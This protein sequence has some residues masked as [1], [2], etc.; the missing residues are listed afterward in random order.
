VLRVAIIMEIQRL[1]GTELRPGRIAA[2]LGANPWHLPFL[3]TALGRH[4]KAGQSGTPRTEL[5]LCV[6]H[7]GKEFRI[8]YTAKPEEKLKAMPA[9]L[10]INPAVIWRTIQPRLEK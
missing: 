7:N 9:V 4:I 2:T 5:F 1:F 10:V 3:D 8:S 6:H